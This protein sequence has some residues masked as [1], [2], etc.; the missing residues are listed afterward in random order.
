MGGFCSEEMALEAGS[1]VL[2][3]SLEY[4]RKGPVTCMENILSPFESGGE[5]SIALEYCNFA[6]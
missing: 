6:Q 2:S 4:K 5:L 1:I 3:I